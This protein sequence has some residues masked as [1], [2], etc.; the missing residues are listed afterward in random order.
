MV[1]ILM[2]SYFSTYHLWAS[3]HFGRKAE[4]LE[5][6]HSGQSRFSVEHRAYV[7]AAVIEA[8]AFLEAAINELYKDCVD[9]HQGYIKT[10]SPS[11]AR[12]LHDKWNAWHANK[13]IPVPTLDK[14][15][16][17]LACCS[18]QPFDKGAAPSQDA[19]LLVR[20]RNALMHFTPQS[21]AEDDPHA[22][23]D[24][25]QKRFKP[26]PLMAQSGNPYFPDK[27][28][29]AGCAA[30]AFRSAKMYSDEFYNRIGVTPNYQSS[31][32]LEQQ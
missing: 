7:I 8:A 5:A 23:G 22:L 3:R 26:N 2:R 15:V 25:M 10:L 17:A 30:W 11:S 20:L 31:G 16:A 28:L 4:E 9:S 1:R 29:G 12:A 27:C 14:Y 18:A 6:A 21:L 13:R 32:F 24:V 19:E